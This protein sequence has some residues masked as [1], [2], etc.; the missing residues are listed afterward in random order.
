MSK[1]HSTKEDSTT[2][3]GPTKWDRE[4]TIEGME[5][6]LIDLFPENGKGKFKLVPHEIKNNEILSYKLHFHH[7]DMLDVWRDVTILTKSGTVEQGPDTS[8]LNL[9][10]VPPAGGLAPYID[11][12]HN[13]ANTVN[14]TT[15][16]LKGELQ[17]PTANVDIFLLQSQRQ[18]EGDVPM[19]ILQVQARPGDPHSPD[20]SAIGHF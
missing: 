13:V 9:H 4:W 3:A 17:L 16:L 18:L 1:K 11:A 15:T 10:K 20:G 19:L 5:S 6:P 2:D 8:H 7:G 12:A 14:S